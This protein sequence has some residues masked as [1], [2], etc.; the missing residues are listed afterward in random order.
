MLETGAYGAYGGAY[1]GSNG[2]PLQQEIY[3]QLDGETLF[4]GMQKTTLQYNRRNRSN[5]LSL[6]H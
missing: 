3:F 2:V 5:G 6:A 4:K 1:G